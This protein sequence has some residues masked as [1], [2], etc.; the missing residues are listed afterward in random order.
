MLDLDTRQLLD[1]AGAEVPLT[2]MEYDLLATFAAVSGG[3]GSW[4]IGA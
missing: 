3:V 2:P 4:L 1:E